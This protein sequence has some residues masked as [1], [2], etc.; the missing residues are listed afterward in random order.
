MGVRIILKPA[1][2]REVKAVF[3]G[4][5]RFLIYE[6]DCSN[7]KIPTFAAVSPNRETGPWTR[8]ADIPW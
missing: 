6:L 5:G 7:A 1:A 8:A 3:T 4:V 2:V